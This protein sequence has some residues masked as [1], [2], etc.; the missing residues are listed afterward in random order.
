MNE[1]VQMVAQK[2]GISQDKAQQ[3]VEVI[4][5]HLKSRLPG[6]MASHLDQLTGGGN[7]SSNN[8]LE[9]EAVSKLGNMFGGE[10]KAS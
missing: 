9:S 4:L 3:A 8:S 10:K 5:S 7:S 2:T 6:P 1:L